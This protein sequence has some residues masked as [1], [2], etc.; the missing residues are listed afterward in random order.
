MQVRG[1]SVQIQG[2][3][4]INSS[5][6]P[7]FVVDGMVVGSI[8]NITPSMVESISVLKGA[9]TSIYGSRGA[10]GVILINLLGAPKIK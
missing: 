3:S 1:N 2:Q 9:A 10:N 7:L 6:E 4:S 8:D 5:T